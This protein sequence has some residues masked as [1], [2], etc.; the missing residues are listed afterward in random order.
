MQKHLLHCKFA[1]SVVI[2][3]DPNTFLKIVFDHSFAFFGQ[4]ELNSYRQDRQK[5]KVGEID[6]VC[7]RSVTL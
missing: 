4:W 6:R 7:M 2:F 3:L 5:G 1:V